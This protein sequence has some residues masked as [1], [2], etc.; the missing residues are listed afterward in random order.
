MMA[1]EM[2]PPL[3][4]TTDTRKTPGNS[5]P[6][7][8][9]RGVNHF[10][11]EGEARNQVLFDNHL[12]IQ[13]GE[14]VIMTGPSGSGKTTLLTLI[15]GL[16][17]LQEGSIRI[18]GRELFGLSGPDLVAARRGVGFIFQ[19]HNL[20]E[21]LTAY[22]NV[23]MALELHDVKDDR[24]RIVGILERLRLGH[25][26]HYKPAQL[27]GGQ[28]Q[29]V[30][31]ARALVN[32]P[33][34]I[35]ADEP[36]AALD[37]ETGRDVVNYLK[38]LSAE[39]CTSLI[40]THDNR[41]LDVASRIVNMVDGRIKSNVVVTESVMTALFLSKVPAFAQL[42]PNALA[43]VA[44]HMGRERFPA[45]SRIIRQ[46]DP[47]DKFYLIASGSVDVLQTRDG[48]EHTLARLGV[49]DFFGERALMTDEPRNATVVA[50][51]DTDTFT[52]KK[53]DFRA[54]IEAHGSLK[55]QLL[56]VYFQ[57]Q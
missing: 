50:R 7:V 27:S 52:L 31:V 3:A 48:V 33:K 12:T 40:V 56:K 43:E 53:E 51:E 41:I 42:N 18:Y 6:A 49:G 8:E 22:Q 38:E 10:F 2:E 32:R 4:A 55:E 44:D 21:A 16:R 17:T 47:G 34:L 26:L 28:R 45:G 5:S 24:Q 15:G 39:G 36:T 25:R 14:I 29:R 1:A 9:I 20:L 30:A 37:A 23:R 35:L 13:P 11:G 54:A 46:G 57:R 19:R